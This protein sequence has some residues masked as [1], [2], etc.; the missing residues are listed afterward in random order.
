MDSGRRV[1]SVRG[2]GWGWVVEVGR[3]EIGIR[4]LFALD[5][6][7]KR[8]IGRGSY[9][10]VTLSRAGGGSVCTVNRTIP[11]MKTI[12]AISL[13][14][15]TLIQSHAQGF[16]QTASTTATAAA[17]PPSAGSGFA[18]GLLSE[19][20][21]NDLAAAAAAYRQAIQE[22]DRQRAQ[23]A[24]AIFRLG[25]VY[26]K[27]G[28]IEEAKVQYA[29][30]LRE[31]SDMV[32][33]TQL[34]HDLL[35]GDEPKSVGSAGGGFGGGGGVFGGSGGMP[36][37]NT[38][39]Q[40]E[41]S[42]NQV[43]WVPLN[44]V[45][46]LEGMVMRMQRPKSPSAESG[47][48]GVPGG[49]DPA[50]PAYYER[51]MMQRYGIV[52]GRMPAPAQQTGSPAVPEAMGDKAKRT[53]CVSNLRQLSLAARVYATDHEGVFPSRIGLMSNEISV[54]KVL[55]CPSDSSHQ[56]AGSWSEFDPAL[57]MTYEFPGASAREDELQRVLFRCPIHGNVALGDGSVQLG[58]GESSSVTPQVDEILRRRYGLVGELRTTGMPGANASQPA[59]LTIAISREGN[60]TVNGGPMVLAAVTQLIQQMPDERRAKTVIAIKADADVE[61][62]RIVELLE[63]CRAAQIAQVTMGTEA[64]SAVGQEIERLKKEDASLVVE[65]E[66]NQRELDRIARA[67]DQFRPPIA[68]ARARQNL[69]KERLEALGFPAD[70]LPA[71][72]GQDA[73]YQR[74]KAEFETAVL[75]GDKAAQERARARL[76]EWVGSIYRPELESEA[77]LADRRLAASVAEAQ[78]FLE[79]QPALQAQQRELQGKLNAAQERMNQL[80]SLLNQTQ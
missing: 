35:F 10:A 76:Q 29:R 67:L 51:L 12:L 42:S 73:R 21:E 55:V 24:N 75:D 33:L 52:P 2:S 60:L 74:L 64:M 17:A 36:G 68:E 19:E 44:Q 25:E 48:V 20:G 46:N 50:H 63:V 77:E 14:V 1:G 56:P 27:M 72:V 7:V 18:S 66:S 39:A 57:H 43:D 61:Y 3:V 30:I 70:R 37:V 79:K 5:Y 11:A 22:F 32:R 6:G 58:R 65:M 26:R 4:G 49:G 71:V 8:G 80:T 54:T 62:Q 38:G 78:E 59:T 47:G 34:S 41:V 40:I 28:A 31:F 23:A 15:A 13:F 45:T 69:A 16:G 9:N 53:V